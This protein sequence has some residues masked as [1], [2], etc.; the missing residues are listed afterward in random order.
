MPRMMRFEHPGSL[1]HI[2]ARGIDGQSIFIEAEDKKEFI[3]GFKHG[4]DNC[5]YHCIAWSLLSNHYHFF[6]R[7]TEVPM[8]GLMRSLNGSYAR[9]F[10][11]KY[12]RRGYLFQDRFKSVLCQDQ[13]YARQLIRYVHLNPLRTGDVTT[14]NAL[15]NWEWCG[16]GCLLNIPGA[17]GHDFQNRREALRRFGKTSDEAVSS[18]LEFLQE[19]I[20]QQPIE[21]AGRLPAAGSHEIAGSNKGWPAVIGDSEF[22]RAAM[23]RHGVSRWRK[24]RQADYGEVLEKIALK[25][26][27]S[28]GIKIEDLFQKGRL[29][30]RSRARELFCY[31]AYYEE[32]IPFSIIAGFLGTTITPV[33]FLAH[34]AKRKMIKRT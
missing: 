33:V 32:K 31:Q 29:D 21:T 4:L 9:W 5:G 12:K 1:V 3:K 2:M 8:S 13:E 18:Y 30:D 16:H 17:T 10:N 6:L 11:H 15:K 24:H 14:L 28:H 23:E 27:R 34:H 19:A 20:D 7:T 22:A 25:V 26:S